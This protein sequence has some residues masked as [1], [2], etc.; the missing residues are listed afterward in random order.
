LIE[1]H[2]RERNLVA[3]FIARRFPTENAYIFMTKSA[4]DFEQVH[5][6]LPPAGVMLYGVID[7]DQL[8]GIIPVLEGLLSWL[9]KFPKDLSTP[10]EVPTIS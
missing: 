4:D 3:H 1:R 5:R 2:R 8:A 7:A 9:S 6:T 10:I